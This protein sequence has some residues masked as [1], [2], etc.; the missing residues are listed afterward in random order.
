MHGKGW[1]VVVREIDFGAEYPP[2]LVMGK[3]LP[4]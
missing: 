3:E 1:E 4:R 2:F